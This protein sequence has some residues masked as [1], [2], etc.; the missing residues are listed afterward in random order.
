MEETKNDTSSE[1]NMQVYRQRTAADGW[2]F[3]CLLCDL[4]LED[5]EHESSIWL[6]VGSRV[7]TEKLRW[8][9]SYALYTRK[10]NLSSKT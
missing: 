3:G 7:N 10:K 8:I 5:I 4:Q 9:E 2:V 1:E 6:K